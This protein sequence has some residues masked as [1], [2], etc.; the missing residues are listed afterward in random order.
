MVTLYFILSVS[1]VTMYLIMCAQTFGVHQ[2]SQKSGECTFPFPTSP[3]SIELS[4]LFQAEE[5]CPKE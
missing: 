5:V 3:I 4:H 1:M 2:L